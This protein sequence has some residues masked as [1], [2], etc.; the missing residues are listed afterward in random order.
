MST[1]DHIQDRFTKVAQFKGTYKSWEAMKYR[2]LDPNSKDY[3]NYGGRGISVCDRWLA[4]DNFLADMGLRPEGTSLD[5]YPDVDGDYGLNNCRWA[6]DFEQVNNRR[7]T[8]FLTCDGKTQSVGEWAKELG[9]DFRKIHDRLRRGWTVEQ[10][11]SGKLYH[12][13]GSNLLT[14]G[15]KTQNI[16]EWSR[17][18]GLTENTIKDR[19][20]L[21]MAVEEVLSP[22]KKKS[23]RPRSAEKAA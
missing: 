10:A 23:G 14:L 21:G 5:R 3:H 22:M 7:N 11:L 15:E 9:I 13:P 12:G 18:I 4:F 20:K 17:E 2:C 1:Q 19:L 16:A 8:R 6:T